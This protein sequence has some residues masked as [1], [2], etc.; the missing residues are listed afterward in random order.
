MMTINRQKGCQYGNREWDEEY[1][2]YGFK[3]EASQMDFARKLLKILPERAKSIL[4][5]ACGIGRYHKV[6]LEKGY[7]VTGTD[8]SEFFIENAKNNNPTANYYVCDAQKLPVDVQYDIITASEPGMMNAYIIRNIYKCL[9]P[10]GIFI[11]ETRNP[12]HPRSRGFRPENRTW[13]FQNGIYTLFRHEFNFVTQLYEH[14]EIIIDPSKDE[15]TIFDNSGGGDVPMLRMQETLIAAGFE[16]IETY[17]RDC[18]KMD[19]TD[20]SVYKIWLVARK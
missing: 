4:D 2:K 10:G 15:I 6:W 20:E 18:E 12:N 11:L 7:C 14:E 1:I 16:E 17:S 3:D 5:V 19:F 8:I 13:S 9:N